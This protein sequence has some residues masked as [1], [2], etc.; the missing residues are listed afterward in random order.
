MMCDTSKAQKEFARFQHKGKEYKVKISD[1]SKKKNKII[2]LSDGTALDLTQIYVDYTD[3]HA[4]DLEHPIL[5]GSN[6]DFVVWGYIAGLPTVE[7]VKAE[8]IPKDK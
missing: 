6:T 1:I 8:K 3:K 5:K 2:L 4:N 7:V